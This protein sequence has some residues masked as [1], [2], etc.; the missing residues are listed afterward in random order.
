MPM[1][2]G[3]HHCTTRCGCK[4]RTGPCKNRPTSQEV[5]HDGAGSSTAGASQVQVELQANR[6]R[7]KVFN[8]ILYSEAILL[9]IGMANKT[10]L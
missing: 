3:G 10:V 1:Q 8:I 9:W 4:S 7:V 2:K 6:E 5:V